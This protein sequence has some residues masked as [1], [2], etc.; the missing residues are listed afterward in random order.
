[1]Q[2]L[3]TLTSF[4][5]EKYRVFL[6]NILKNGLPA[7]G[8]RANNIKIIAKKEDIST[9][10]ENID[11][12]QYYEQRMV[13]LHILAHAKISEQERIVL[14]DKILDYVDS[15]ALCDSFVSA[16]KSTKNE[17]ELY[18]PFIVE[19]S[20]QEFSYR[21]RFA[22]VMLNAYF[23]SDYFLNRTLAI[24]EEVRR[25]QIEIV[26]AKAWAIVTMLSHHPERTL[27]WYENVAIEEIVHKKVVQKARESRLVGKDIVDRLTLKKVFIPIG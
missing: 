4:Q 18:V 16:L 3:D 8:V 26:M 17:P 19:Q 21:V 14:I 23:H 6:Q 20:K 5:D 15:W 25:N 9:L 22:L 7:L 10:F 27:D 24:I 13:R 11:K 12:D 2:Y 1:M